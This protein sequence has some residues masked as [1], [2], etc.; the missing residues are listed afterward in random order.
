MALGWKLHDAG[1][2]TGLYEG[3]PS[4]RNRDLAAGRTPGSILL[5]LFDWTPAFQASDKS[6]WRQWRATTV[7]LGI[8]GDSY[9]NLVSNS[10]IPTKYRWAS[11]DDR[12]EVIRLLNSRAKDLA[13]EGKEKEAV[14]K[15]SPGSLFDALRQK[16][17][18]RNSHLSPN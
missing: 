17:V 16:R 9:L 18:R 10:S 15:L 4:Q 14:S 13:E 8:L 2:M 12:K 1:L 5:N 11:D 7:G 6:K 3:S